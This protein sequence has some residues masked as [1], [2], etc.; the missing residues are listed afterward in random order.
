VATQESGGVFVSTRSMVVCSTYIPFKLTRTF[1][2]QTP[3][4]I[5]CSNKTILET[6]N[7][8]VLYASQ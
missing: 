2:I 7:K 4:C 8:L 1:H 6:Y 3:T 5:G